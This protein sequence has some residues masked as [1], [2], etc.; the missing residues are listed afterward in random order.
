VILGPSRGIALLGVV[1]PMVC[2]AADQSF[3]VRATPFPSSE[4]IEK[5]ATIAVPRSVGIKSG[6]DI[7]ELVRELC[8][9]DPPTYLKLV[10]EANP[11]V[12]W[13]VASEPGTLSLPACFYI[14]L[15]SRITAARGDSLSSIATTHMAASGHLSL[16]AIAHL[17]SDTIDC[18]GRKSF[19][20]LLDFAPCKPIQPKTELFLPYQSLPITYQLTP[21][22]QP[23]AT[24]LLA[25]LNTQILSSGGTASSGL[26]GATAS[27]D[28]QFLLPIELQA[29]PQSAVRCLT[30]DVANLFDVT[31]LMSVLDEDA[32]ERRRLGQNL[33]PPVVEIA[34]SGI[35][36]FDSP[37]FPRAAF[38]VLPAFDGAY[39][40]GTAH[41]GLDIY[42]PNR[43][44]LAYPAYVAGAHGT[45]VAGLT[46][47]GPG[48][49]DAA[50]ARGLPIPIQL[51]IV[52]LVQRKEQAG[53]P[54]IQSFSTPAGGIAQ[55][56]AYANDKS[57]TILNISFAAD[58]LIGTLRT[59]LL[60]N[61][62]LLIVASAGN[63]TRN[64]DRQPASFPGAY[65]GANGLAAD[66]VIT[67]A[68][69]DNSGVMAPFSNTG[70]NSVDL[71]A[72]GC[73]VRSYGLGGSFILYSGTSQAA[74]LVS[75][76]AAL[77]ASEGI[78]T[79][80]QI[81]ARIIS[82]VDTDFSLASKLA[83]S[84]RLNPIKALSI[85][86]DVLEVAKP[87]RHLV[88]GRISVAHGIVP[89]CDPDGAS[90]STIYK[91]SPNFQP[92]SAKPMR[93]IF[94]GP[95]G[96]LRDPE[97][98][99]QGAGGIDF[100]ADGEQAAKHYDWSEV[101]DVVPALAAH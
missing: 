76:V 68:A 20:S 74:P 16:G 26:I 56:T 98:C 69:H 92:G 21:E 89:I 14:K 41:F 38:D 4:A 57:A 9:S 82:S 35:A 25:T 70:V 54:P 49:V 10:R 51:L 50:Q 93:V 42:N 87:T 58:T 81:K 31:A 78:T 30:N 1:W 15:K 18:K 3:T 39:W 44:P 11:S 43:A 94:A 67:V 24:G 29:A 46:R 12:S 90:I 85:Y 91:I 32:A 52:N 88:F 63:A 97:Y 55:A 19:N 40:D 17:N 27:T 8:G 60:S 59:T 34:D 33:S 7:A 28:D 47:G 96:G 71:A 5:L 75:F 77:L 83:S 101:T 72:P 64:L 99:E 86:R 80:R 73:N 95:Q 48:F 37:P 62:H 84:G 13:P 22:S 65:G 100:L 61:E 53:A 45:H 36:A 23:N 66:Q 6:Q 2:G 79:A